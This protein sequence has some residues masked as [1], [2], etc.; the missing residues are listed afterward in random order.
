MNWLICEKFLAPRIRTTHQRGMI[1]LMA[2]VGDG[3]IA[4]AVARTVRA[5]EP[6]PPLRRVDPNGCRIAQQYFV[7]SHQ[8]LVDFVRYLFCYLG[9]YDQVLFAVKSSEVKNFLVGFVLHTRF[10]SLCRFLLAAWCRLLWSPEG[11]AFYFCIP[12]WFPGWC[13]CRAVRTGIA[14]CCTL[15]FC[16]LCSGKVEF[17][18]YEIKLVVIRKN[19]ILIWNRPK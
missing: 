5:A 11:F 10:C 16:L 4:G 7:A 17:I 2:A 12:S 14:P 15:T 9:C 3:N 13:G 8:R 6:R 1:R 19:T 18:K